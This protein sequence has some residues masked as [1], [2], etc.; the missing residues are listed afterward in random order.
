M[1]DFCHIV[2]TAFLDRWSTGYNQQLLLAHLVE[3]DDKYT[4]FYRQYNGTKIL[5][6]SAFEMYKQDREMYPSEKLLEMG[7]KVNAD[8]IIMSDY[9]DQDPSVTIKAAETQ[10]PEFKQAGFKTF[11]CPQAKVGDFEGLVSS[12]AWAAHSPLVDY[13]GFSILNIPNAYGVEQN[14]KLQR[15]LSRMKFVNV[16][17]DEG[18]LEQIKRNGKK[19]HFLGM[20]DGP[21]EIELMRLNG[22]DNYIS[23][24]DSSCAVWYGLNGIKFDSSPSGAV[25][26]KFEEEVDFNIKT[27]D[28][29]AVEYNLTYIDEMCGGD[30]YAQEHWSE[31]SG[32]YQS[33]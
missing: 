5:D 28:T 32:D 33:H 2:P 25:N 11:F 16:L 10:A 18:I 31:Q 17:D 6:N 26:G 12:F 30:E 21:N 22:Y 27:G 13:I 3:E 4:E 29:Q 7:T 19:I 8:Y 23:T 15:Y 14:N 9:P 20:V 24:W 1:I